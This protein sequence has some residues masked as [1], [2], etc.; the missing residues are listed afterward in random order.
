MP[1]IY[2]KIF[3][4]LNYNPMNYNKYSFFFEDSTSNNYNDATD[5]YYLD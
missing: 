5:D 3:P 2:N 4:F 1:E